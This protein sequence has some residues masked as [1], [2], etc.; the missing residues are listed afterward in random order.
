MR[1]RRHLG[2]EFLE[3]APF[4][5]APECGS[6]EFAPPAER[7]RF[8]TFFL[9]PVSALLSPFSQWDSDGENLAILPTFSNVV[10]IW[11]IGDR[12]ATKLDTGMKASSEL[13]IEG[14]AGW[15]GKGEE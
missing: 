10:L 4:C 8:L 12:K 5:S 3:E 11:S 7:G 13:A 15:D 2:A 6:A 1:L 14:D 9:S